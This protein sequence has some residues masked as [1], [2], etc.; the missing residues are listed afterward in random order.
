[1]CSVLTTVLPELFNINNVRLAQM[2][3]VII[4]EPVLFSWNMTNEK[5]SA[6]DPGVFP[7]SALN[8]SLSF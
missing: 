7:F 8:R 3:F 6:L 4:A 1:V 5:Y 2:Y